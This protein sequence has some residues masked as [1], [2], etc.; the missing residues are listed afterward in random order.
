MKNLMKGHKQD[1][2]VILFAGIIFLI[3]YVSF[4][5][6][7]AP[8]EKQAVLPT[9][10]PTEIQTIPLPVHYD[11]TAEERLAQT[12]TQRPPLSQAD[13]QQKTTMLNTILHGFN[14]GVLYETANVRIEYVQSAELLMAEVKTDNIVKAKAEASTWLFSQGFSQEGIC[15]L[16]VMFYLDPEVSQDLQGQ[17]IIFSPLP[18]R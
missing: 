1:Y 17:N 18:N 5:R 10:I 2:I 14:S 6:K 15:K 13:S 16:P 3:V 11:N 12:L 4:T 8:I 7:P 9:S